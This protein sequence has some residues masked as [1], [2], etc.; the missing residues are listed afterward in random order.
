MIGQ[1]LFSLSLIGL[2]VVVICDLKWQKEVPLSETFAGL[3]VQF[4]LFLRNRKKERKRN[5]ILIIDVGIPIFI[6]QRNLHRFVLPLRHILYLI[7][8]CFGKASKLR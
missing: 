8:S 5:G 3:L 1:Y 6:K 4:K 7:L 2:F